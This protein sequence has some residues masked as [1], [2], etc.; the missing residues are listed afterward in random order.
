MNLEYFYAEGMPFVKAYSWPHLAY[1]AVC[2]LLIFLTVYYRKVLFKHRERIAIIAECISIFQQVFLLY[3]WS[4]MVAANY[5]EDGLPLHMC[6]VACI[7]GVI[8]LFNKNHK[9]M[10]IMFSFGIFA[11][12]SL[13]YPAG[14]YHFLHIS[15]ISYMINHILTVLIVLF[16]ALCYDWRPSWKG[17]WRS[18]IAFSIFMPLT[19]TANAIIPKANYFYL[20]DR[21][22]AFLMPIPLYIYAPFIYFFVIGCFALIHFIMIELIKRF[23]KT[24]RKQE[25]LA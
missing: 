13:F 21:P 15:G 23:V 16:A 9:V 17:F 11:L 19:M 22:F 4:F 14:V 1:L 8:F 12:V 5:W 25:V 7:C 3:G 24:D 20:T 6:R 10:D 2:A 18:V